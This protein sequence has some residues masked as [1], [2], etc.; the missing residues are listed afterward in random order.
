MAVVAQAVVILYLVVFLLLPLAVV[1]AHPLIPLEHL[2]AQVVA[3]A[4]K[5]HGLVEVEHLGKAM[6]V[7]LAGLARVLITHQVVVEAQVLSVE[8]PT[9]LE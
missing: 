2:A 1:L 7:A 3:A 6:R 5:V 8:M 4:V 9:I